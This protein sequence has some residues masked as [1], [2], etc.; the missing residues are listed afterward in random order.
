MS[1]ELKMVSPPVQ[2]ALVPQGFVP[3]EWPVVHDLLQKAVNRSH[4][5]WSMEALLR[6]LCVGDY[7]L[8]IVKDCGDVVAAGVTQFVDYPHIR[9]LSIHFLGGTG[10]ENWGDELLVTFERFAKDTGC[11][12]VEA[13]GRFGFWPFFKRHGYDRSYCTYDTVFEDSP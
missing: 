10:F 1:A 11:G 9:M 2:V 12:G 6:A 7:H 5:R 13:V 8:W 3:H 4:G